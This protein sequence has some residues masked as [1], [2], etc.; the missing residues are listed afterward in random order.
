[1]AGAGTGAGLSAAVPVTGFFPNAMVALLACCG[2]V[3]AFGLAAYAL[4]G[5]DLRAVVARTKHKV[6]P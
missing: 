2:A 1:V 6:M 5:G 4:D 3:I